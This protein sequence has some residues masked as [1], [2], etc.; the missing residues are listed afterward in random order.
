MKQKNNFLN[1]FLSFKLSFIEFV[2][3]QKN[4]FTKD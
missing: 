2:L 3:K 4:L 1:H